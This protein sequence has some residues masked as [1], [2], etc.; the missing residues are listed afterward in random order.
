NCGGDSDRLVRAGPGM[1][2]ELWE[3]RGR[4]ALPS[5]G[6]APPRRSHSVPAMQ[7]LF[8]DADR[9]S[10]LERLSR[11]D[12]AS[13]RQWGKMD[14]AQMLTHCAIALEA[15]TGD[16]PMKQAF[17][18]KILGPLARGSMLGPKPFGRNAPTHPTFVV[19]D[20]RDFAKERERLAG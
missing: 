10:I 8:D 11:L 7:T 14:P 18:G 15:A 17:I 3:L 12:A 6:C 16:R 4:G 20:A 13:A 9:R 2:P 5:R 19:S 1:S